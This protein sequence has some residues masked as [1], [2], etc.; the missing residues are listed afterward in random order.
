MTRTPTCKEIGVEENQ[1]ESVNRGRLIDDY[2]HS[3]IQSVEHDEM[4]HGDTAVE[5]ERYN[6][7]SRQLDENEATAKEQ[8]DSNHCEEITGLSSDGYRHQVIEEYTHEQMECNAEAERLNGDYWGNAAK[9]ESGNSQSAEQGDQADYWANNTAINENDY[10][11]G[12]ENELSNERN[13]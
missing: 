11:Q 9:D 7:R 13:C 8:Y 3:I 6:E 12:K 1:N 10:E 5:L 4:K 2:K